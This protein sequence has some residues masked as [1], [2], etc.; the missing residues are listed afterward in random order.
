VLPPDGPGLSLWP[1]EI[2]VGEV[3]EKDLEV[4]RGVKLSGKVTDDET[5]EPVEGAEVVVQINLRLKGSTDAEGK[6][7]ISGLGPTRTRIFARAKGYVTSYQYVTPDA[8]GGDVEHDFGLKR[9]GIVLGTVLDP[10]G[11]PV[12]G[13]RIGQNAYGLY[14][15]GSEDVAISEDDGTYRLEGILPGNRWV[16]ALADGYAPGRSAAQVTVQGGAE[17]TG[18][19]I[20]LTVGGEVRGKV[21]A[22][23][24]EPVEGAAV[25]IWPTGRRDPRAPRPLVP[26]EPARSSSDGTFVIDRLQAGTYVVRVEKEGYSA[27]SRPNV[28]ISEGGE[29]EGVDFVLKRGFAVNGKVLDK[30]GQPVAGAEIQAYPQK[31]QG[32]WQRHTTKSKEDGSFRLEGLSPGTYYLRA[33]KSGFGSASK[34]GVQSGTDGIELTLSEQGALTGTAILAQSGKPVTAYKIRIYRTGQ[35]A[36]WPV[37]QQDVA[38]ATGAFSV[39]NLPPGAYEIDGYTATGLLSTRV[40]FEIREGQETPP[41]KLSLEKGGSIRGVVQSPDGSPSNQARVYATAEDGSRRNPVSASTDAQGRFVLRPLEPGTYVVRANHRQWVEAQ[42]LASVTLGSETEM[43]LVLRAGGSARIAVR[44]P[45]DEPVPD[46]TVVLKRSDGRVQQ[47]DWQKHQTEYLQLRQRDPSYS[48]ADFFKGITTTGADGVAGR[49]FLPPDRYS[50]S[51][52][53]QGYE[54]G[55]GQVDVM[56]GREGSVVIKLKAAADASSAPPR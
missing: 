19:D 26:P 2:A 17:T 43:R 16:F 48:W 27:A 3:L 34:S 7:E 9:G 10:S 32:D 39:T 31:V 25:R 36:G 38:D 28:V 24:G 30:K 11:R 13:A 21:T 5:G 1:V 51:V 49:R 6:Y 12:A 42:D 40:A 56:E 23:S 41:V 47:P 53:K 14:Q 29:V 22:E 55:Q 33:G 45:D 35:R 50:V 54:P 18:I 4:T 44:G 8:D 46:A 52:A 15:E 20:R 37:R